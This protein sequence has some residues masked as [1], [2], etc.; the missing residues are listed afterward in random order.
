MK[1]L[2]LHQIIL[3]WAHGEGPLGV[4]RGDARAVGLDPVLEQAAGAGADVDFTVPYTGA[5]S[6]VLDVTGVKYPCMAEVAN[7][8]ELALAHHGDDLCVGGGM[9]A[10]QLRTACHMMISGAER[11]GND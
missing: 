11:V 2:L 7:V 1:L 6:H 10:L 9:P 3:V 8:V 4:G 5:C